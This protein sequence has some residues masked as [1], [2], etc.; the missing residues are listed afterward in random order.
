MGSLST[1]QAASGTG[2][3]IAGDV[4]NRVPQL[5]IASSNLCLFSADYTNA[6]WVAANLAVIADSFIAP[7]GITEADT[8]TDASAV[9]TG[10]IQQDIAIPNDGT[11]YVHS[12]YIRAGTSLRCRIGLLLTGG[13][14]VDNSVEIHPV[15][16]VILSQTG[17]AAGVE[18]L[19]I[20]TTIWFRVWITAT[21]N[22]S[23]NIIARPYIQPASGNVANIGSIFAWG[24]QVESGL[25]IPTGAIP[26]GSVAVARIA[27]QLPPW[28]LNAVLAKG[29]FVAQ[30]AAVPSVVTYTV[31]PNDAS[32]FVSGNILVTSNVTHDFNFQM[33]YTD[34]SN[35]ART[36]NLSMQLIG[37]GSIVTNILAARGAIPYYAFGIQLRAKAGTTIVI[38]TGGGSNIFTSVVYNVEASIR[39]G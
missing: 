20:G 19:I 2:S 1:P 35:T 7:N 30:T 6:A 4:I 31:G 9:A 8:L 27:G 14:P 29:R 18:T 25:M 21:N 23:G 24:A 38:S 11:S 36:V 26:T 16:G 33:T 32:L 17:A 28:I 34:E 12:E 10:Q 13:T 39:N 15:S 22:T 3:L 37:G 5:E